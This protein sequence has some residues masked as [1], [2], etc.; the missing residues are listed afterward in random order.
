MIPSGI[1]EGEG[2]FFDSAF[3]QHRYFMKSE[4][5]TFGRDGACQETSAQQPSRCA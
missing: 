5:E 1:S 3:A 2:R 4:E